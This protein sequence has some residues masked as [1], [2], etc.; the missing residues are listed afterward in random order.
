MMLTAG[1][2]DSHLS[3]YLKC[4]RFSCFFLFFLFLFFFH[5]AH[6]NHSLVKMETFGCFWA[7]IFDLKT[8]ISV[9]WR[10]RVLIRGRFWRNNVVFW[11][12]SSPGG[13]RTHISTGGTDF[14]TT[15]KLSIS[16]C[17]L[18]T[19]VLPGFHSPS[20]PSLFPSIRGFFIFCSVDFPFNPVVPP[21]HE[22]VTGENNVFYG[23]IG[24]WPSC[25]H[26]SFVFS[27]NP[28]WCQTEY[29]SELY[30]EP[31]YMRMV[32]FFY[33]HHT[34]TSGFTPEYVKVKA[35]YCH[36]KDI[37][38]LFKVCGVIHSI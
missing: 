32:S 30:I 6:E 3:D 2:L 4:H 34:V 25:H 11:S 20:S 7:S 35:I 26:L 17:C 28:A 1:S 10:G 29:H 36:F 37:K 33:S 21:L 24:Q 5:F 14:D 12:V 15:L 31:I 13:E 22:T 8:L 18:F 23:F 16:E 9:L 19:L 27:R 38:T